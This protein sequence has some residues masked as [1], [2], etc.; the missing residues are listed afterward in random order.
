MLNT[1]SLIKPECLIKDSIKERSNVWLEYK[2]S[3]IE[4]LRDACLSYI[5]T[6]EYNE[7]LSKHT[8]MKDIDLRRKALLE[9]RVEIERIFKLAKLELSIEASKSEKERS[10]KAENELNYSSTAK[11]NDE[12]KRI[13][14]FIE[15]SKSNILTPDIVNN[16]AE[17]GVRDD[18]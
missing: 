3:K 8:F 14:A 17:E 16:K 15:A 4:I 6:V 10:K 2:E 5:D 11:H 1:D 18:S 7:I 9:A 13:E 12:N